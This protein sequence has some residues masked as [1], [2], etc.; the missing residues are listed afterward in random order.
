M[1]SHAFSQRSEFGAQER[2]VFDPVPLCSSICLGLCEVINDEM[3]TP[4]VRAELSLFRLDG[5]FQGGPRESASCDSKTYV[6]IAAW[7]KGQGP[8]RVWFWHLAFP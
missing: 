1:Y 2:S 8:E 3:G 7:S 6:T 5:G 4:L